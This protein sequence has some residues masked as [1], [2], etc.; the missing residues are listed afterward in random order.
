MRSSTE[1]PE[2]FGLASRRAK[3]C[4]A[5]YD[6]DVETGRFQGYLLPSEEFCS[7]PTDFGSFNKYTIN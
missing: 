1:A 3:L 6:V 5:C 7:N 2:V 4:G